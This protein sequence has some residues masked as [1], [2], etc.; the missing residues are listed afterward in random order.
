MCGIGFGSSDHLCVLRCVLAPCMFVCVS[1]DVHACVDPRLSSDIFLNCSQPYLL[2][3][4]LTEP[5]SYW[6]TG[7]AVQQ[8]REFTPFHVSQ[9]QA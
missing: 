4:P 3:Q 6:L 7:L 9:Y 2:R 8:T 1:V 5:G